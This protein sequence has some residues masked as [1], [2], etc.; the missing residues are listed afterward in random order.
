MTILH[1]ADAGCPRLGILIAEMFENRL[2]GKFSFSPYQQ[3]NM[4][5]LFER[6]LVVTKEFG[7]ATDKQTCGITSL[8]FFCQ[9]LQVLTVEQVECCGQYMRFELLYAGE[10]LVNGVFGDAFNEGGPPA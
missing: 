8:P 9:F 5:H 10:N 1:A 6:P 7:S 3:V 4:W 2:E